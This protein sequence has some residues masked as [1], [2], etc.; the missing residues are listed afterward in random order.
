MAASGK[1]ATAEDHGQLRRRLLRRRR[2][3][4]GPRRTSVP[5][6]A[7]A[8]RAA[9]PEVSVGTDAAFADP[10]PARARPPD[11]RPVRD[12]A[13]LPDQRDPG[14]LRRCDAV[15]PARPGPV[16]AQLHLRHVLR[17]L[18]RRPPRVITPKDKPY[19]EFESGEE[20]NNWLLKNAEVRALMRPAPA[21]RGPR[22]RWSSSTRRPSRSATS[23][24][25]T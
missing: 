1:K 6:V 23:S 3:R 5:A 4:S 24:A 12:P 21:G 9:R 10:A 7:R 18:G 13:L 25:M 15:Q 11:P 19:V 8:G 22:W 2:P 17:R 16:G 20:I 14:L